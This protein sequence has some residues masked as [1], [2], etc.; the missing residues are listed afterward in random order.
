ME[1]SDSIP[2]GREM[3]IEMQNLGPEIGC[4]RRVAIGPMMLL[5]P[6]FWARF[7]RWVTVCI[8]MLIAP[9]FAQEAE[10]TFST[11]AAAEN[12][13]V[14]ETP[15]S[16]PMSQINVNWLYGSYVPKDVPLESLDGGQRFK[17]YTR[18][19]YTT[20]GIYIKT[21]LFTVH[22]QVHDSNPQ[23]GDGAEGFAKRFGTREAQFVMQNS[24]NSL[25]DG[26][27]GW[28]PRY[29]R[30]RCDGFWPRTRHAIARN[31][32]TYA[33]DEKSLRPQLMPYV[34]AFAGGSVASTW[35]PATKQWW[36]SGYQSAVTQVLI[37]VGIDWI[38]EFGPEIGHMFHRKHKEPSAALAEHPQ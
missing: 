24:V 21:M 22:D 20:W 25:G 12:S 27:L 1:P 38:G 17:L 6:A 9:C 35:E 37:G 7:S 26:L 4:R 34:G 29:D 14:S 5:R 36:V 16:K 31:F 8:A 33:S 32:V 23:W 13:T 3:T 2:P 11:A 15:A 10:Q 18:Q 28:E 30:C 19:T